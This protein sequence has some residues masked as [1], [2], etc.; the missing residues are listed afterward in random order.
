MKGLLLIAAVALYQVSSKEI[1]PAPD[2][3]V[4]SAGTND[5]DLD[6]TIATLSHTLPKTL[7]VKLAGLVSDNFDNA[8]CV[9][10]EVETLSASCHPSTLA[11]A[12]SNDIF[13]PALSS[14]APILKRELK[15]GVE[16]FDALNPSARSSSLKS[17]K[18]KAKVWAHSMK[19]AKRLQNLLATHTASRAKKLSSDVKDLRLKLKKKTY[20]L[21]LFRIHLPI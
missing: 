1:L 5:D 12:L 15:S 4:L 17:A 7:S 21:C 16:E 10:E 11:A 20:V 9:A 18:W 3:T 19:R 2:S 13:S 14:F 8:W 6:R